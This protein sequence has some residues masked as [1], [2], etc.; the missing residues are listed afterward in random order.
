MAEQQVLPPAQASPFLPKQFHTVTG[1]HGTNV[2]VFYVTVKTGIPVLQEFLH[3]SLGRHIIS[4]VKLLVIAKHENSLT[5]HLKKE[6]VSYTAHYRCGCRSQICRRVYPRKGSTWDP[7]KRA[8]LP[9]P[10][11]I[12]SLFCGCYATSFIFLCTF[13]NA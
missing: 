12:C 1:L 4:F 2:N 11:Q 8:G 3:I 5:V 9:S 7:A 6:H 10:L 13:E